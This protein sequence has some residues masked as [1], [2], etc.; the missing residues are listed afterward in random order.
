M[1][2]SLEHRNDEWAVTLGAF[3]GAAASAD[4]GLPVPTRRRVWF[5]RASDGREFYGHMRPILDPTDEDLKAALD[6]ALASLKK[7]S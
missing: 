6:A 4:R 5:V 2:R 1:D 3:T 7:E